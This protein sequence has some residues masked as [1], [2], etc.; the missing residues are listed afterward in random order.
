MSI[1]K[2]L[3]IMFLSVALV[4]CGHKSSSGDKLTG[5]LK[6]LPM[7]VVEPD[8]KDGVAAVGIAPPSAGG[9][10]FQ[11][12]KAEMDGRAE[13]ANKIQSEITRV[14]KRAMR[15]ANVNGMSD[16]EDV[17]SQATKEVVKN[18]SL[19]GVQRINMYQDKNGVLYMRMALR[20]EDYS[21][22]ME[23]SRKMYEDQLRQSNL[24]K[25]NLDKAQAAVKEM[26]DE[27]ETERQR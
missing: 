11:I 9:L 6:D 18:V 13:V 3:A 17:F 7:W 20:G 10:S 5:D 12:K 1:R 21:K 15:E 8:I 4:S 2:I 19:S 26:F 25:N 27:L 16:A 14:S 24:G 22:Y 23:A